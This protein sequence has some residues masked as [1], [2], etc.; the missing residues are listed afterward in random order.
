[1]T[2]CRSTTPGREPLDRLELFRLDR[3]LSVNRLTERINDA[4]EHFIADRHRDDAAGSLDGVAF[5]DGLE[6]AEQNRA[7][8]VFLEVQR[9]PEYPVRKLE[10]LPRHRAL[11]TME[12]RDAVADGDDGADLGDIDLNGVVSDLFANDF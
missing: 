7:H 5:F 6:I 4:P 11:D 8:A 2:G 12:P 9:D 10:H 3:S 1:M